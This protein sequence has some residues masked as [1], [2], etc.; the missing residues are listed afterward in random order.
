[1]SAA[2]QW[3]LNVKIIAQRTRLW[4]KLSQRISMAMNL[5]FLESLNGKTT[6][7]QVLEAMHGGPIIIRPMAHG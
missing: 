2:Q 6:T 1:V 5:E 4:S 7:E 3:A